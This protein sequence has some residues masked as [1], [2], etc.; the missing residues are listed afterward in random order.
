MI[1]TYDIVTSF[2]IKEVIT[3]FKLKTNV[4]VNYNKENILL[5]V[6]TISNYIPNSSRH[7]TRVVTAEH[8]SFQH[9]Q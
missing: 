1:I 6:P 5:R 3:V 9:T 7:E 4:N 2:G 8:M